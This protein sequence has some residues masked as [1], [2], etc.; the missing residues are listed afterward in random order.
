MFAPIP[1]T[2]YVY[3]L[4][5]SWGIVIE[6]VIRY[7]GFWFPIRFTAGAMVLRRAEPRRGLAG[8]QEP[9]RRTT[10]G[11]SLSPFHHEPSLI[12]GVV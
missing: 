4:R 11:I 7:K 10:G 5:R 9:R 3:R 12:L 2:V 6:K 1:E 8:Q